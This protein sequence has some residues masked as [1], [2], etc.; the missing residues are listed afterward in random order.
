MKSERSPA[1][2]SP[3]VNK[4]SRS[5]RVSG[6]CCGCDIAVEPRAGVEPHQG[7]ALKRSAPFYHFVA[8]RVPQL[9]AITGAFQFSASVVPVIFARPA[10][11]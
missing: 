3:L 2:K 11:A 6:T 4:A 9:V 8:Y 7:V 1:A 10:D 5:G